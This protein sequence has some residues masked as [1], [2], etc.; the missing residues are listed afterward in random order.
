[1][2]RLARMLACTCL[3]GLFASGPIGAEESKA[4]ESDKSAGSVKQPGI[5]AE[6]TADRVRS[7]ITHVLSNQ[8]LHL[9]SNRDGSRFAACSIATGGWDFWHSPKGVKVVPVAS[10]GVATF[11]L[12]AGE[13]REL[14]AFSPVTGK[15]H[16]VPLTKATMS[17]CIPIVSQGIACFHVDGVAYAF[18]PST[19]KWDVARAENPLM[20]AQEYVCFHDK[21]RFG[22]FSDNSGRWDVVS[23]DE[24]NR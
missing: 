17:K 2:Y 22:L 9:V 3:V 16:R 14:V 24:L 15:W 21:D 19:G 5:A 8:Q 12:S 1:M 4:T 10:Q 20:V 11:E 23:V 7:E 13:I 18:S 6:D